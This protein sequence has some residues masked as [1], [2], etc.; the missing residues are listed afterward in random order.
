LGAGKIRREQEISGGGVDL[1][2]VEGVEGVEPNKKALHGRVGTFD[3]FFMGWQADAREALRRKERPQSRRVLPR[4]MS[5]SLQ[6]YAPAVSATTHG[7]GRCTI[8]H[9]VLEYLQMVL[10]RLGIF[11]NSVWADGSSIQAI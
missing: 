8:T 9:T 11:S 2:R 4:L 5:Q 6:G 3:T 10:E 7:H 1:S